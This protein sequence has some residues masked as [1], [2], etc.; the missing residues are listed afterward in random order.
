MRK[1][2]F[3]RLAIILVLILAVAGY[4]AYMCAHYFFYRDYQ[5]YL[6]GYTYEEGTEFAPL[7][8]D[9]P[10]V[11][12]MTLAAENECLKLYTDLKTTEIAVYD[13]RSGQIYRSNPADRKDDPIAS[14]RNKIALNS[15]FYLTYYD[16]TMT[17]AVWYNSDYSVEREQFTIEGLKDGIRYIYL[18]GDLTSPT[19]IV[20]PLITKERLEEKVLSKLSERNARSVRNSYVES[21]D[22]PG[23]MALTDGML[24]SKVGL[25]KLNKLFEEAGYTAADFDEDAAMAA[26]GKIQERTTFSIPLEYRLVGDRLEVSIPTGQIVETGSSRL[27][28]IDLLNFFGA[29]GLNEQGYIFVPNGS[30]SLIYFNNGKKNEKYNQ[31]VY[32]IDETQQAFI[33]PE[34]TEKIRMPVFGIKREDSAVFAEITNGDTLANIQAA[35]SGSVNGYNC[36]WPSFTIRG[37]EKVSMFGAEGIAADVPVLEK[38][39]YKLELKVSYAFL[40]GSDASYSGMANCYRKS[41][42]DRGVL[43]AKE[44]SGVIPF[45]LDIVGGVQRQESF[46]GIQYMGIFPMTTFDEA[47]IIADALGEGGVANLRVN[48]LGW[49]NRGYYHQVVKKVKVDRAL[50]GKNRLESLNEKLEASGGR[51]YGDVAIQRVSFYAERNYNW[52]IENSQY[53]SGL[54]V[55]LSRTNP[56]TMRMGS[57]GYSETA[58][59]VLSPKYVGRYTD[60][61]LKGIA[62]VKIGGV[63]LRDMGDMAPSDKRRSNI[64]NRQESK[65][66]IMAQLQKL[67]DGIGSLMINGGNAYSWAYATDLQNIPSGDSPFIIVDEEIPFYQMVIH[68]CIDYTGEAI[69][70]SHVYDRQDTLLR[71]IEY[72]MAPH[73]VMSYEESSEIKYTGMNHLYSTQYQIW[74]DEAVDMYR[75][76]NEV[77]KNVEGSAM[78]EHLILDNGVR[79]VIYDNG[80]VIYVNRGDAPAECDGMTIPAKGYALGGEKE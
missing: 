2:K 7:R 14:G 40:A 56:A 67:K 12:G 25:Q 58:Y 15:Q 11:K 21:S 17:P 51:L 46:I 75:Q 3:I 60:S 9:K 31:Y 49:F 41:L 52:R 18:L 74:L 1:R 4:A 33:I 23:F 19:G 55:G 39:M 45:Y 36:V 37:S 78:V 73:Y 70:A 64:I 61:F 42:M 24:V 57:L 48:Y 13:K 29:G 32:G 69:N 28:R 43:S 10:A 38:N 77:L 6:T 62:K 63:S 5:K 34:E 50:G 65:Q 66:I 26:G 47:A 27:A 44:E 79:K 68:G 76:V 54:A 16:V 72:G 53:Y 80:R 20:P 8:D 35:V 71:L 59:N 22:H 30:G